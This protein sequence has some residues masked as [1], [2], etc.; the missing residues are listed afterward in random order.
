MAQT[1]K[2]LPAM[3]ETWV[4][5]YQEDPL[6]EEM[7]TYSSTLDWKDPMDGRAWWATVHRVAKSW[8]QLSDLNYIYSITYIHTYIHIFHYIH[9][10]IYY[11]H[12]CI[13]IPLHT[14]IHI[15]IPLHMYV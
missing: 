12:A 1:V 2:S 15:Y 7:A 14:Y 5:S 6:E 4:Q 10:Y 11:I 8:T 3:Q 9:T 13:Y